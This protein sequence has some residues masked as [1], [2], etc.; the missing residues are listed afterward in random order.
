VF[1]GP[2]EVAALMVDRGVG[3]SSE[4]RWDSLAESAGEATTYDVVRGVLIDLRSSGS[5]ETATEVGWGLDVEALTDPELPSEGDGS[6][7]VV[8]GVNACGTGIWGRESSGAERSIAG[9]SRTAVRWRIEGTFDGRRRLMCSA[10]TNAA[11]LARSGPNE[12]PRLSSAHRTRAS[13][14]VAAPGP[15]EQNGG[16]RVEEELQRAARAIRKALLENDTGALRRLVAED[17][18]G[19]D[20]RGGESGRDVMLVAYA[21]GGVRLDTYETSDVTAR[22]LGEVGLM[23]GIGVLHGTFGPEAFAHRVRFLDV[24][25][26]QH[27]GWRLL[28]SQVTEIE[29]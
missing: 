4:L 6:Y 2:G 19:V 9:L 28:T 14:G 12:S 17:Y 21:P 1:A 10:E 18:R 16:V 11:M 13:E 25:V 8:R 20:P 5:H 29:P 22:V 7:Y 27:G 3:A 26:R 24:Y 23:R 15:A